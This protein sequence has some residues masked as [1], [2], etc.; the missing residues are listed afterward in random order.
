MLKQFL[1]KLSKNTWIAVV[2]ASASLL[3]RVWN[4][5]NAMLFLG[6]QGRD[7]LL[8]ANIFRDFDP[9]FIGPVTSIGNM[10]LG[11]A[12]YYFMLP[13]L[14]LS[15]PS[16]VG[17]AYAIALLGSITVFCMYYWGR[18]IVGEKAALIG[19]FLFA[20]NT[21]LIDH[22]R[23]SWN[24]NPAPFVSL[25]LLWSV[26][27]AWR[28]AYRYWLLAAVAISLLLQL[29]Y[30]AALAG[31]AAA[32]IW[33]MQIFSVRKKVSNVRRL[34][35][36]ALGMLAIVVVSFVP[37]ILFDIKHGGI[38]LAGFQSIIT[39]DQSFGQGSVLDQLDKAVSRSRGRSSHLLIESSVGEVSNQIENG[40]LVIFIVSAVLALYFQYRRQSWQTLGVWMLIMFAGVG[41]LGL[42]VYRHDVYFH[43]ILFLLPFILLYVGWL[44]SVVVRL[45]AG[46]PV[47]VVVLLLFAWQNFLR[48]NLQPTG[49]TPAQYRFSAEQIHNQLSE[50]E[51][52][53][54]VLLAAHHDLYGMNYRYYLSIDRDKAALS[55]ER[56]HEANTLVLINEEGLENPTELPI[57][58]LEVFGE[59]DAVEQVT[60]A[61]DV[62]VLILRKDSN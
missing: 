57:F 48:L 59:A 27:K 2:I 19:S 39:N 47:L 8:V 28:G 14:L 5:Q 44:L 22:A 3:P 51:P 38:N 4:V 58:E 41:L 16:P 24:P 42:I 10:Y 6:D 9:V 35:V 36:V 31:V 60:I 54:L 25:L 17:P 62:E 61:R 43:Y 1:S 30:V 50:N 40:V 32:I 49:P 12:Y 23:F 26:W 53:I 34:V 33:C 18:S 45:R 56:Y 15:Y 21:V 20:F 11:P 55:P 52:Y 46:V 29:H 7:A 13:F 37:L